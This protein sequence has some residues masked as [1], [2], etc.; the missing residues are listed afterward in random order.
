MSKN[1]RVRWLDGDGILF[2]PEEDGWIVDRVEGLRAP[3]R[4]STTP[5]PQA[6][7]G[8]PSTMYLDAAQPIFTLVLGEN[9]HEAA[10]AAV[11]RLVASLAPVTY[12]D[13]NTVRRLRYA[14]PGQA[15]Y[16]ATARPLEP[17]IRRDFGGRVTRATVAFDQNDPRWYLGSGSYLATLNA[18]PVNVVHVGSADSPAVV[19]VTC[20]TGLIE[21]VEIIHSATGG[22][23]AVVSTF[24]G[25][26]LGPGQT[27]T[28]DGVELFSPSGRSP[29]RKGGANAFPTWFPPRSP[30]PV[31]PPGGRNVSAN[32]LLGTGTGVVSIDVDIAYW[33][34]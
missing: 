31:I 1:P 12:P 27:L 16:G 34:G 7:G 20:G 19:Q 9:D 21:D 18:G 2:D 3:V 13:A 5:L 11:R 32:V 29:I 23:P 33:L 26:N 22:L 25:I 8:L 17:L 28:L 14:P 6:H 30:Y 4:Q 15:F 10:D 24:R